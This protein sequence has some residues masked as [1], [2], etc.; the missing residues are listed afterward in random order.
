VAGSGGEAGRRLDDPQDWV[1]LEIEAAIKRGVRIIPVLVDGARMP[2][3]SELPSSLQGLARRQAV[4]LN[5]ASLDTRGLVSVLETVLASKETGQQQ[6]GT[7][8][9]ESPQPARAATSRLLMSALHDA[10]ALTGWAKPRA[11]SAII[12]A[13]IAVAPERVEWLTAEPETTA[14]SIENTKSRGFA[15]TGVAEAVAA[16]DPDRAAWLAAEAEA[17]ARSIEDTS[18]RSGGLADVVRV[19]AA[20]DP[21]HAVRLA[22]EAETVARSIEDTSSRSRVLVDVARAV[23]AVDP[24]RAEVIARSIEDTFQRSI[25][26]ADLVRLLAQPYR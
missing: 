25:A 3:A 10:S 23:A 11:L 6:T 21:E 20:A 1:R 19:V 2:S 15:L 13:A 4:A 22:A 18:S 26:L 5:P 12:R 7:R 14:R 16:A 24:E 17:I 9:P 8:A